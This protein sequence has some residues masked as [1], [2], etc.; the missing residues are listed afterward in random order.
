MRWV[1]GGR[2][3][4]LGQRAVGRQGGAVGGQGGAADARGG[5]RHLGHGH[6]H[7][8]GHGRQ[9]GVGAA[10]RGRGQGRPGQRVVHLGRAV[11]RGV[12]RGG[13]RAPRTLVQL[14]LPGRG[15]RE[16]QRLRPVRGVL[17]VGR[18]VRGSVLLVGTLRVPLVGARQPLRQPAQRG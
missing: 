9:R 12:G 13:T 15:G 2:V 16:P 4:G 3:G 7:G 14:G 1:L 6:G 11:V 5:G 18:G 8:H 10:Q 17:V